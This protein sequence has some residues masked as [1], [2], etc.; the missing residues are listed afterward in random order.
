MSGDDQPLNLGAATTA[1]ARDRIDRLKRIAKAA[2]LHRR[3]TGVS[4]LVLAFPLITVDDRAITGASSIRI[5]PLALWPLKLKIQG[6]P[7]VDELRCR[8]RT[9]GQPSARPGA[10]AANAASAWRNAFNTLLSDGVERIPELIIAFRELAPGAEPSLG[11]VPQPADIKGQHVP[12]L[13]ASGA[14][15]VADFPSQ[16][17]V[18]DLRAVLGKP[19]TDT[20]LECL[21]HIAEARHPGLL[22]RAKEEE[23]FTTL[24]ADPSQEEAVLAARQAPGLRLEGPPGTGKSQTIVNIITD[25][26]GRGETIMLVCEKQAA[27][28]VVHKRLRAEGLGRR[29]V[30]IEDTQSDR[31]RLLQELQTHIPQIIETQAGAHNE[32]RAKRKET[33]SAIDLLEADLSAYHEAV[34]AAS[35]RLGL[36]YRDVV[37]RIATHEPA[38]RGLSV[39]VLRPVLGQ[40]TPRRRGANRHRVPQSPRR[41]V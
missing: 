18:S 29:V 25:C 17:I 4:A 31:K 36:S 10:G 11:P 1:K 39:P 38:A 33:A 34:Y 35:E 12:K 28:E 6:G 14:I 40:L 23:R 32:I 5:A 37:A 15:M 24:E 21:L 22:P 16:E 13:V 26:L 3:E 19:I 8:T 2:D 7:R 27:L 41:L 9:R 30:R 20:A